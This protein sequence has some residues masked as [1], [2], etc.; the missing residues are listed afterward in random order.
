M[1]TK[2]SIKKSGK[3]EDVTSD[4]DK[5]A[6]SSRTNAGESNESSK[7]PRNSMKQAS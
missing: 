7:P 1:A 2:T 6:A 5:E 3:R 4:E